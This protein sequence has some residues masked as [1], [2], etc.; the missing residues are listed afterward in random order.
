MIHIILLDGAYTTEGSGQLLMHLPYLYCTDRS[1]VA[2]A[3]S[4]KACTPVAAARTQQNCCPN[5][6]V[7]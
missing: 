6:Q 7:I 4:L 5:N 2:L 1:P 3:T